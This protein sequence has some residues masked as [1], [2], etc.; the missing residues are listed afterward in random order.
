M[1]LNP[2]DPVRNENCT[3]WPKLWAN[4]RELIAIFSQSVGPSLAIWANHVQFSSGDFGD[5]RPARGEKDALV[6]AV[7]AGARRGG[8]V[9]VAGPGQAQGE[10]CPFRSKF[11]DYVQYS[12][13]LLCKLVV[14]QV[15]SLQL[16][17]HY[18]N[19]VCLWRAAAKPKSVTW[20]FSVLA[21]CTSC[22]LEL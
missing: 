2:P 15:L 10:R 1:V 12:V 21:T 18:A 17:Y 8:A 13:R 20:G 22:V 9:E 7:R 4:F 3:G 14:Y 19:M 6:R 16:P 11:S 5:L